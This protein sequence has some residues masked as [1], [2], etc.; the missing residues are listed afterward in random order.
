MIK[1]SF[2][3]G[4]KLSAEQGALLE[5]LI[6]QLPPRER[7]PVAAIVNNRLQE[8]DYPLYTDSQVEL[9]DSNSTAGWRIYRRTLIFLL[10]LAAAELFPT[11]SLHVSHS[12]SEGVFCWLDNAE[13]QNILPAE[14]RQ[15]EQK[16]KEYIDADLRIARSLISR[17]D[18]CALFMA[19]GQPD[20]AAQIER[21]SAEVV[22]IYEAQGLHDFA[23]DLLAPSAA[24]V[25]DFSLLPYDNGLVLQLPVR[26]Y[27]SCTEDRSEFLHKKLQS[28]LAE[29]HEWS[30]LMGIST[31]RDLNAVVSSGKQELI[32]LVLISETLQE[33][34]LHR[35]ADAIYADFPQVK[36]VLLA[37]PS[38][39]GKTTTTRRLG[40]QFRTLGIRPVIIS[41]DDY[42]VDRDKT[43]LDQFGRPDFEGIGALDIDL[44]QANM[45]DLLS[46]KEASLPR[47]D[48]KT[49][50]SIPN[51]RRLKLEHDQILLVE[52]IH[53]LNDSLTDSIDSKQK[54]KVYLSALTQLNLDDHTPIGASENRL[55]RRIVRDMQFR[56]LSPLKT[57][58]HWDAV[59]RGE[60]THIFPYQENAD[61]FINSA[62]IYEM[63]VLAPLVKKAL[64]QVDESAGRAYIEA[65]R[66]MELVNCFVDAPDFVVPRS[67]V[68][69]EFVGGSIFEE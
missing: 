68:L 35:V 42:Y 67:S 57:L 49:G 26:S 11:R 14:V 53:A 17:A 12:L 40:I 46:G 51:H 4:E 61:F 1:I 55:M 24:Y 64:E 25:Q 66:L 34:N 54:R 27:L 21:L 3:T 2:S 60:H 38:C 58:E 39:S 19:E 48:F 28:V 44:F 59:R 32:D 23:L 20:K 37:G 43:P 45:R 36:L 18:A 10:Q 5:S 41:M 22:T 9:L 7:R 62:M 30:E 52:G 13:G 15:L 33:R 8:L 56:N 31:V 50:T 65:R 16:M 63:A 47:F 6:S 69:C 29:Y